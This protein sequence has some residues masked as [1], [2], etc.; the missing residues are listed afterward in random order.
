[1]NIKNHN[2]TNKEYI[3]FRSISDQWWVE[4]GDFSILH[5][6]NPLRINFIIQNYEKPIKKKNILDIGCGGGL[7]SEL[8]AKKKGL[9]LGIDENIDNIKQA[10]K[11]ARE[12]S[13]TV[14]YTHLT[15]PTNREV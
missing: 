14:S 2:K 5:K 4:N 12:N 9:V 10:K 11:H 13:I 15:L 6:I 7:I 8:L 1:M 3:N